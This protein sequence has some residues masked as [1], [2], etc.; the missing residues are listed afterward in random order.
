MP[1]IVI[2]AIG[3]GAATAGVVATAVANVVNASNVFNA[4][5]TMYLTVLEVGRKLT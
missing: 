3:A 2:D 4:L 1:V 5:R